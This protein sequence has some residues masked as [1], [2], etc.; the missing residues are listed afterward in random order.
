MVG[1]AGRLADTVGDVA[2]ANQTEHDAG[3]DD[4]GEDEAVAAVPC[5]DPAADGGR[6]IDRVEHDKGEELSDQSV[7]DWHEDGR[8]G[9]GRGDDAD[10][11]ALV[12][13]VAAVACPL[14]SPVDGAEE[15]ENL[16]WVFGSARSC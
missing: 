16:G 12:A 5:R 11:V 14:E 13:L 7:L 4:K 6:A 8:P 10:G 1:G 15:G 2:A 9:D 3:A